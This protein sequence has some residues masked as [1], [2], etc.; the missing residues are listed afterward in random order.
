MSGKET[1]FNYI[2]LCVIDWRKELC[3]F[4]LNVEQK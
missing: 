1:R 2:N 4:G 3:D